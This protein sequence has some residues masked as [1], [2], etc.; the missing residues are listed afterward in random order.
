MGPSC[1]QRQCVHELHTQSS[2]HCSGN[3][4]P[5]AAYRFVL[6]FINGTIHETPLNGRTVVR[7][8]DD[9]VV[10]P[11]VAFVQPVVLADTT[12]V[13]TI[14]AASLSAQ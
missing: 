10:G 14:T 13:S 9:V 7:V 12:T 6:H 1:Q 5:H 11:A 2:D 8:E 4:R 3:T